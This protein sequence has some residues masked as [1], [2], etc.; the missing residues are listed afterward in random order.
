MFNLF[1]G[2]TN[3]SLIEVARYKKEEELKKN[4]SLW[5]LDLAIKV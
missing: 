5:F 3:V 1:L 2:K 4:K